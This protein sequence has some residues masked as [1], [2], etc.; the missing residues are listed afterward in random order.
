MN[1]VWINITEM[2]KQI[3][4]LTSAINHLKVNIK[5][6][7]DLISLPATVE[8]LQKNVTSIGNTLNICLAVEAI[9]KRLWRNK[10]K[11]QSYF[12]VA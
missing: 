10:R 1:K 8:G 5:L 11:P 12:R 4:L 2:N 3:S 7:A 6:A 9:Q